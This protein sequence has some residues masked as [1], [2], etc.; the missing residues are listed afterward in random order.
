MPQ[1][2]SPV[3]YRYKV[4]G[5]DARQR[6]LTVYTAASSREEAL[7]KAFDSF[8]LRCIGACKKSG[9]NALVS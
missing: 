1:S 8:G 6:I 2:T 5:S 7:D 3:Q 4:T 9:S